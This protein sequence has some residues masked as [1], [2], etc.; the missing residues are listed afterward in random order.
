MALIFVVGIFFQPKVLAK[1]TYWQRFKMCSVPFKSGR[2]IIL[3]E[4]WQTL[5]W[6]R[7]MG[8]LLGLLIIAELLLSVLFNWIAKH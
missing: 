4:D 8:L 3:K 1:Y 7:W 2:S 5:R 6:Y